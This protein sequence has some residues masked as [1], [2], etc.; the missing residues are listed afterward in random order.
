MIVYTLGTIFFPFDR[1][2]NWLQILLEEEI[3]AEH[4]LLQHGATSTA[5]LTHPLLTSV[6]SLSLEEMHSAVK[7]SSLV[8]SHAGQG[9]TRMLAEL[10]ASFVLIPRLKRY[11][12]HV[13]DHQLLF[14]RA[15]EKF[16]IQYCTEIDQL[17]TY[18]RQRPSP[19]TTKLFNAPSLAD[20]LTVRYKLE[21]LKPLR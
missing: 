1:A 19:I 4:V 16:G 21:L 13:D 8:I 9:S 20:H 11:G 7:Q 14:A 15:V 3:I 5:K 18:V 17:I 6:T 2:I 10:G 12:E